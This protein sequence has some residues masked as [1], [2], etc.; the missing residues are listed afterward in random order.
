[1]FAAAVPFPVAPALVAGRPA[2]LAAA[3]R[4]ALV[5]SSFLAHLGASWQ[6]E[7]APRPVSAP[8]P[9]RLVGGVLIV[10]RPERASRAACV[11]ARE[12]H[13]LTAPDMALPTFL[14][15]YLPLAGVEPVAPWRDL[16]DY[17][18]RVSIAKGG[19]VWL[20]LRELDRVLPLVRGYEARR[21]RL[22][23]KRAGWPGEQK[24]TKG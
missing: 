6:P 8:E 3:T 13:R 14:D 18:D 11:D 21:L 19:A 4:A 7:P 17:G 23:M 20:T 9:A 5:E 2:S 24:S 1:M 12:L 15:L 22:R 16:T 10:E